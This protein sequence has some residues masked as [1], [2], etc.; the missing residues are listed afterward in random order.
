MI[1]TLRIENYAIIQKVELN[2]DASLNIITGET[3]AGKSI[4]LGA[5][6]LIM[7]QRAD[8][9]VLYNTDQKCIVEVTFSNYPKHLNKVLEEAD[10]DVEDELIIRR[11]ISTS[12][13]S[14]AFVNDTPSKLGFLQKLCI[15]LIDLNS[16]FEI[17]EIQNPKFHLN[18]IDAL[19]SN[20]KLLA[21]YQENYS[22]FKSKQ[23]ALAEIETMESSQIKEMDFI[24]FQFD[25]LKKAGLESGELNALEGE[26]VLLEKSEDIKLLM[27]E[28]KFII[29]DAE[30]NVKETVKSLYYKWDA[31]GEAHQD[32]KLALDK[33]LNLDEQLEDI[34]EIADD[35]N[36][37]AEAD[38]KRLT[39]VQNRLDTIYGLQRK[40]SV[41]TDE[42]LIHLQNELEAKILAF[43]NSSTNKELLRKEIEDLRSILS[44]LSNDL[45][46]SRQKVFKKLEK[47]VNK[48]LDL[49]SMASAEIKVDNKQS[50]EF[51][52]DG[53]DIINILFKA[54]KGGAF[55]PIKKVAS[56]GESA[57]LMLSIKSTVAHVMQLPTMIFDEIDTGVSG[58]VAGKMGDI[59]KD[60]S[61][62]HQLISITHSPQV[63]SRAVKHFFVYKEDK[64]KRTITHVKVI[65]GESRVTEIAKMLSGNPPS[66]FALENAKELIDHK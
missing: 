14:R 12:G 59:L 54:N 49:L 6:S 52:S 13:K 63:A 38:P 8:S 30:T 20:Q 19:A 45:T 48:K 29:S 31:L 43:D 57:R 35:I 1:K 55:L 28:T 5:L 9:K 41:N 39:E 56:G 42:A 62:S 66:T 37:K 27:D 40:H 47:E 58:D 23:K 15:D 24:K 44:K 2:F 53:K 3:G 10:Y 21:K 26:V 4:I 65:E 51:K 11:E 17:T 16:Q 36:S 22:L 18:I 60:L 25:E 64:A 7:G 32:I 50:D 46:V 61:G 34:I 33:F